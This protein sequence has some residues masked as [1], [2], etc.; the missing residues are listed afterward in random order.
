MFSENA[1][2][3]LVTDDQLKNLNDGKILPS[4]LKNKKILKVHIL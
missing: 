1:D 4:D 2:V 3:M